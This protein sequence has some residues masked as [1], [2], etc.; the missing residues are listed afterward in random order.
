LPEAVLQLIRDTLK[1]KAEIEIQ[2]LFC[3]KSVL[4]REVDSQHPHNR[5]MKG[6]RFSIF[7]LMDLDFECA[8]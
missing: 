3:W 8:L 5:E 6:E 2:F 4:Q 7:V 1:K